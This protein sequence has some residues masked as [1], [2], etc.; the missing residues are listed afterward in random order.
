MKI[1]TVEQMRRMDKRAIE[2]L[3]I[4]EL[5]LMENAGLAAY[6][7]VLSEIGIEDR[8]FVALCGMGNNGGDGLVVARKLHSEGGLVRVF[9][10]GDPEKYGPSPR[11]NL[12][13]LKRSGCEIRANPSMEEVSIALSRSD[14][15][16]DALF[17]TGITREISGV[18]A[19]L[20]RLLNGSGSTVLSLDIPSGVD[21]NT[22][23]IKGVAVQADFT[24]TF[25]LPKR[26]NLLYPGAGLNGKLYVTHISFP[27]KLHRD[28]E[29]LVELSTPAPLPERMADGHKKSFGDALFIAGAASYFG[30]PAFS[31]MSM[32]KAGGGYARLAA[33]GSVTPFVA[34]VAQELVFMPQKETEQGSLSMENLDP[35]LELSGTVDLVVLGPGMSLAEETRQLARSLAS[36]IPRPL[37]IDGDGLTAV[38]E[39][40]DVVR[41]RKAPTVLTPHLGEMARITGRPIDQIRK[42][43]IDILQRTCAD[44][45]SI[46]VLKGA[47]SLTGLPDGR[48]YIN[49]SGNSGMASAGSGDVLT[50]T[51]AAMY[52]LGLPLADA[53]RTG[54]FLHGFAGDL[55]ASEKG[56]D[57]ITG[58]D[59]LSFLPRA[60]HLYRE[61]RSEMVADFYGSLGSL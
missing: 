20:I 6:Y 9:I 44:L 38:A 27:P 22:G 40:L 41:K 5:V 32:L 46:I 29:I 10:F 2:E 17:G 30:A 7:L 54:V 24:V 3:G 19:D 12:E 53:A 18:H 42:D 59:I 31:A 47:H 26:G 55:A 11:T 37:I 16:I 57:G 35:L 58:S 48:V 34:T 45:G 14:L 39:D 56:A 13:M 28:D 50:G 51:M 15:V 4:P 1:A 8:S 36:E 25:G 43:R 21:G 60:T 61:K 52:G 33:P 49:T 23:Q